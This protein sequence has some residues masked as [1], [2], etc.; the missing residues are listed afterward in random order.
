MR[1]TWQELK[2]YYTKKDRINALLISVLYQVIAFAALVILMINITFLYL[3]YLLY[4]LL[5]ALLVASFINYRGSMQAIHYLKQ[6]QPLITF[7][8]HKILIEHFIIKELILIAI[9]ATLYY[10]GT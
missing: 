7:S 6:K 8:Y 9:T 4:F 2:P 1:L 10:F 3:P 5:F